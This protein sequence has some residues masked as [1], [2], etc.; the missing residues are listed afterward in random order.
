[1][2]TKR[3]QQRNVLH[4]NNK[5]KLDFPPIFAQ[6]LRHLNDNM[7]LKKEETCNIV[8]YTWMLD[9]NTYN[10]KIASVF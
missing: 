7:R 4:H 3:N 9:A 2:A 5:M 10:T 1:M 8:I 6:S